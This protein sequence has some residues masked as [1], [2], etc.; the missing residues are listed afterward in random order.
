MKKTI[1]NLKI[2]LKIAGKYKKVYLISL[3]TTVIQIIIG[4]VLPLLTARQIVFLT[5]SVYKEL[6]LASLMVVGIELLNEL[7]EFVMSLLCR[8]FRI[9][10]IKN[11][12]MKLRRRNFK[13]HTK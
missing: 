11:I 7:N 4:V 5:D 10:T 13:N 9:G 1:K 3:I 12:Q 2:V 8:K 6:I